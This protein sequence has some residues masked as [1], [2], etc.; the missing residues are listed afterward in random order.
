MLP[1]NYITWHQWGADM[2]HLHTIVS[3]NQD[4]VPG[5]ALHSHTRGHRT[6]QLVAYVP[7]YLEEGSHLGLGMLA[8]F[9]NQFID[10]SVT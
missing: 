5:P 3:C 9:L 1:L 6:G 2:T 10:K 4:L 8:F 7:I